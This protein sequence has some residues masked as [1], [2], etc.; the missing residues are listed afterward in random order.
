MTSVAALG[1]ACLAAGPVAARDGLAGPY[2]A[3]RMASMES[4]Y[5]AAAT[6]YSQ[7]LAADPG[8]PILMEYA[9]LAQVALGDMDRAIP[10]AH[11]LDGGGATSQVANLVILSDLAKRG[12]FAQA[13]DELDKGRAVGPLVEGLYRAWALLGDGRM[14]EAAEAFDKVAAGQGLRDFALYHKA[15]ALASVGDFEAAD[16]IFSG[17]AAGPLRMTRRGVLAHAEVLSALERNPDAVELIDAAFGPDLDPALAEMRARLAAGEPLPFTM[18]TSATDGLSEV[19]FTVAGAL[20]GESNDAYSLAYARLGEFLRPDHIDAILLT[21]SMLESQS[22]FDLATAVYN[23]IP[24]DDPSFHAAELGRAAALIKADKVE[25]AIEVLQQ[26]TKSHPDLPVVWSTLGDT[27]R[28][29]ERYGEAARAYDAA[30]ALFDA[31]DPDQ[32]IVYHSRGISHER[33]KNWPQAEADFRRALELNP[34]QPQV[35]NYLGYSYVEMNENLIEALDMIERAVAA[36]PDDGYIT[37][38]LG[39]ALYKMGRYDDA[40]T[41]M[42]KAVELMPVDPIIN[43]HLGDV[44]WAVGRKLEAEFQW[45]RAIS[46]EPETEAELTR[47]REKLAV[48]LDAVLVEEG[49]KPLAV[50]KNGN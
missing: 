28:R 16:A 47:I 31:P 18:L 46:F 21:A 14:S 17:E 3:A 36:R 35:L 23:K 12:A 33:E 7:A 45:K 30:I 10:I 48:G 22:Q 8:N 40:V 15:L 25:A 24:R 49:A 13:L 5:R 29:A 2:L 9:I 34:D 41:H 44:Y 4:D 39:W 50:T 42:E 19:F 20:S 11:Q 38:S 32:W 43:D 1:L 26:L 37:D 6:Y 27:L